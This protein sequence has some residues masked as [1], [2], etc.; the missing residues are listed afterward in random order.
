MDI[1][2]GAAPGRGSAI[3]ESPV[4]STG[5]G[6]IREARLGMGVLPGGAQ[7]AVPAQPEAAGSK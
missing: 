4:P 3:S 6:K 5:S 2:G 7:P 1:P